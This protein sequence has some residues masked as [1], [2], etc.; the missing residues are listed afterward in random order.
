[1]PDSAPKNLQKFA[2]Q[3][4]E[5]ELA[6]AKSADAADHAGFRV[7]ER[8]QG[9]LGKLLGLGG[10]RALLSRAR[11]LAAAD[12]PWLS[13][14]FIKD[15]SSLEGF[16]ALKADLK[17]TALVEGGVAV[18]AHLLGLLVTFI[19]PGLMLAVVKEAWPKADC[20]AL[21]LEKEL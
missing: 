8:L 15:D 7:C 6:G 21:T 14:L 18:V 4:L 5:L 13:K 19:G 16:A 12:H 3:L 11:S 10:F 2:R 1:M 17:S 9:P 20:D